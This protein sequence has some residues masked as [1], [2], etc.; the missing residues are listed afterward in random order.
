MPAPE[1]HVTGI[2]IVSPAGAGAAATWASLLAG[3]LHVRPVPGAVL[4]GCH[5]R[6]AG[7]AEN[8]PVPEEACGH[9]RVCQLTAAALAD[10]LRSAGWSLDGSPPIDPSRVRVSFGTS[11]GGILAFTQIASAWHASRGTA[12][13]G[14]GFEPAGQGSGTGFQP[15]ELLP[16]LADIPPDAPARW[17][18]ARLGATGGMH[19]SVAACTTGAHAVIRGAQYILDGEADAVICG[20][21]DASIHPLWIAAFERMGVLA[22]AHPER[23]PNY[24]CRPFDRT[25]AGFAVGEGA[26]VLILESADA[27][28]RRHADP[29]GRLTGFATGTDPTGLTSLDPSGE[30]LTRVIRDACGRARCRPADLACIHAHGTGTAGNDLIEAR[31]ITTTLGT[32]LGQVPVVS[33]KGS[34]GHMLGA[35]GAV[36][37][38]LAVLAC[39]EGRSP[40]TG[41]LLEL[42]PELGLPNL[43]RESFGH[44]R[45]PI[46]KTSLG[47]GGHLAA[48]VLAP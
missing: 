47:F 25:R 6:F 26:A 39:R 17:I 4:D 36:E 20:G 11:K 3:G 34:L 8:F 38:A 22:P 15:V 29:L 16:R 5:T 12:R 24:A 30:P 31:A 2:G 13:S 33:V 10:A 43:P 1:I 27:V 40:G 48:V 18:A 28:R 37:I 35:A 32:A 19:T 7:Q 42:D 44:G 41:T 23:G 9:D 46:L 21:A 14:T 45:G